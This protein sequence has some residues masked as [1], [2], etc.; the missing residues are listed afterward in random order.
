MIRLAWRWKEE[1]LRMLEPVRIGAEHLKL[2]KRFVKSRCRPRYG[3]RPADIKW[4]C[5]F[6]ARSRQKDG[7]HRFSDIAA[8]ASRRPVEIAE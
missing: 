7:L 8:H 6:A 4:H 5:R 1:L 3:S 2:T